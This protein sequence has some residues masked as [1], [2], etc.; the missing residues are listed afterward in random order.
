MLARLWAIQGRRPLP[1][2]PPENAVWFRPGKGMSAEFCLTLGFMR[3]QG[4]DGPAVAVRLDSLERLSQAAFKLAR[5]GPFSPPPALKQIIGGVS[6]QDVETLLRGLGYQAASAESGVTFAL[7][8]PAKGR[9]RKARPAR[10]SD[11]PFAMLRD[12]KGR[13]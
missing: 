1:E 2:F 7:K 5:Q 11:S 8:P 3:F 6:D 10:K 9:A 13:Q 4:Q 12:L